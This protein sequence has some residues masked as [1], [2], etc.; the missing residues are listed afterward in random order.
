MKLASAL[1][2]LTFWLLPNRALGDAVPVTWSSAPSVAAWQCAG[3]QYGGG[4]PVPTATQDGPDADL[5]V[6]YASSA[7][8]YGPSSDSTIT[9]TFTLASPADVLLSLSVSYFSSGT[10]CWDFGCA[11]P[12]WDYSA[13]F[14]GSVDLLGLTIPFSD[15]GTVPGICDQY[16]NC[17][18]GLYLS[19]AGSQAMT[20]AA[21]T[22]LLTVNYSDS[23]TS[24]GDSS[25]GAMLDIFLSDPVSTPEPR[26]L[27]FI[28]PILLLLAG[29]W[30]VLRTSDMPTP[31]PRPRDPE[32]TSEEFM[33]GWESDLERDRRNPRC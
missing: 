10:S 12:D 19:D 13:E 27:W 9:D 14:N 21:G 18:A 5:H 33:R 2:T 31:Q 11:G 28:I 24:V 1:L 4:T 22:Y 7:T 16:G 30:S 15:S 8:G 3:C 25:A 32:R 17:S 6:D 20:L 23:D 26:D 29:A